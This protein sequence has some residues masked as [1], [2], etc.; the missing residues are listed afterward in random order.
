VYDSSV[1]QISKS[2]LDPAEK[3]EAD[4]EIITLGA[5]AGGDRIATQ[6]CKDRRDDAGRG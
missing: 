2:A 1:I 6:G 3:Y 5:A 4:F